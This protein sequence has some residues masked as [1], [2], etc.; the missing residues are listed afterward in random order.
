MKESSLHIQII[1]HKIAPPTAV[2]PDISLPSTS[3]HSLPVGSS[4]GINRFMCNRASKFM[5]HK[6]VTL[7]RGDLR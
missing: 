3:C 5:C 7:N 1:V 6:I 4:T 2:P